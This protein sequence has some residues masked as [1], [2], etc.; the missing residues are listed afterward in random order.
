MIAWIQTAAG[1]R[2]QVFFLYKLHKIEMFCNMHGAERFLVD[3]LVQKIPR[4]SRRNL[5]TGCSL[6]VEENDWCLGPISAFWLQLFLAARSGSL[7]CSFLSSVWSHQDLWCEQSLWNAT[8]RHE[9]TP[10]KEQTFVTPCVTKALSCK[11][12]LRAR[13]SPQFL[14]S[15]IVTQQSVRLDANNSICSLTHSVSK[16]YNIWANMT[17]WQ[18]KIQDDMLRSTCVACSGGSWWCHLPSP[19]DTPCLLVTVTARQSEITVSGV[20]IQLPTFVDVGVWASWCF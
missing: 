6:V 3:Q 16:I 9:N 17:S 8:Q 20:Y 12:K 7:W 15:H 14:L 2:G 11:K 10:W 5:Q 4:H 19:Q 18:K 1:T 13:V